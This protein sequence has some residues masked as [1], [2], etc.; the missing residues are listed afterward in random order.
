MVVSALL[1]LGSPSSDRQNA[2]CPAEPA[3][4]A[5]LDEQACNVSASSVQ[6]LYRMVVY[7]RCCCC[8][9]GSSRLAVLQQQALIAQVFS[10]QWKSQH[11]VPS[12]PV[13]SGLAHSLSTLNPQ[14]KSQSQLQSPSS[15]VPT[16]LPTDIRSTCCCV[17]CHLTSAPALTSLG[18][19][20]ARILSSV[21]TSEWQPSA[22]IHATLASSST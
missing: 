9:V 19:T 22:V 18:M 6:P 1:F 20:R 17:P 5:R 10:S 14:S 15:A 7:C 13:Q 16:D 2:F 8:R 4:P 12:S 11:Q 21:S 3:L